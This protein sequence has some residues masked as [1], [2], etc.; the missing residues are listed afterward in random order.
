MKRLYTVSFHWL[1]YRL[2]SSGGEG[3]KFTPKS[4]S[5]ETNFFRYML[6]KGPDALAGLSFV[7]PGEKKARPSLR[8]FAGFHS[9]RIAATYA[10]RCLAIIRRFF[11]SCARNFQRL[12]DKRERKVPRSL[13]PQSLGDV[14][15]PNVTNIPETV[16]TL[17]SP[18]N[19]CNFLLF[20]FF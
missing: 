13:E 2:I 15:A 17:I 20:S 7:S 11:L 19:S 16:G 12:R 8:T 1:H 18:G 6:V 3:W 10:T 5:P 9:R 4:K 14:S